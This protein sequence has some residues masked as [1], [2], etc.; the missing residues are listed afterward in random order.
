MEKEKELPPPYPGGPLTYG[1][2]HPGTHSHTGVLPN[3]PPVPG[4]HG[5]PQP[6]MYPNPQ[7]PPDARL[8]V[9]PGGS[10]FYAPGQAGPAPAGPHVQMYPNPEISPQA[11][12]TV[13]HPGGV[14]YVPVQ[15]GAGQT[16]PVT[17]VT[18]VVTSSRLGELPGYT[19]CPHCHKMVLTT[20]EYTPGC[21][22]WLICTGLILCGLYLFCCLIPFCIRAC[23]D[24]KHHCPE[25]K[26]VVY[27]YTRM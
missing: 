6:P 25:C 14:P 9:G 15:T 26:K 3:A 23:K 11:P 4:F 18:H 2:P 24:V 7:F 19:E 8:T 21:L 10:I 27:K 12:L 17:V 1:A 13:A 16:G 20:T 22:T 5:G